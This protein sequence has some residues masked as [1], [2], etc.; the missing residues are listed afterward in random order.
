[1]AN[2]WP[3][4]VDLGLHSMKVEN[5]KSSMD[6][7]GNIFNENEAVSLLN[8]FKF[9]RVHCHDYKSPVSA[10]FAVISPVIPGAI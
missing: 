6:L 3:L 2:Q 8:D 7:E 10:L 5:A 1:M 4:L 9:H